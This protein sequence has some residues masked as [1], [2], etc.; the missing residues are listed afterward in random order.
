MLVDVDVVVVV[1]AV[2]VAAAVVGGGG[3]WVVVVSGGDGGGS[4]VVVVSGGDG[5]DGGGVGVGVGTHLSWQRASLLLSL[6][7]VGR[8]RVVGLRLWLFISHTCRRDNIFSKISKS[9]MPS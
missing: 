9:F 1:V 3:S 8:L 7:M 5:G 4:W 6:L 2:G